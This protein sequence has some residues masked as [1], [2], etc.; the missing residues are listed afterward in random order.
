MNHSRDDIEKRIKKIVSG[1]GFN[2]EIDSFADAGM[3][4][5][6]GLSLIIDIDDE[7]GINTDP[8]DSANM[9]SISKCVDV[10]LKHYESGRSICNP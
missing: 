4:S 10:V 5:L 7:F 3:D 6:D 8:W 2:P 9:T 1:L